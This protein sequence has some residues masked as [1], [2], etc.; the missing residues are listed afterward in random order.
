MIEPIG[1]FYLLDTR[2]PLNLCSFS[3]LVRPGYI[4][5]SHHESFIDLPNPTP[6]SYITF[7]FV[8]S[9]GNLKPIYSLMWNVG[10]L[11]FGSSFGFWCWTRL[12]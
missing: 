6:F 11:L 10:Q 8:N 5:H 12:R 1:E 4:Y 9:I 2:E 7:Q 3:H